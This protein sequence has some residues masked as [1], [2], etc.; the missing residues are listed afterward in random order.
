M[1]NR[2]IVLIPM[3]VCLVGCHGSK[4]MNGLNEHKESPIG[5][6]NVTEYGNDEFF[7]LV[8]NNTGVVYLKYESGYLCGLTVMTHENGQPITIDE[9]KKWYEEQ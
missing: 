9:L 6:P 8:D 5:Y 4:S 2:F 3:I 7:Y 1:F